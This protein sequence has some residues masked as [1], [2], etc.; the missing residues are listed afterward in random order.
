MNPFFLSAAYI[1]DFQ[2]ARLASARRSQFGTPSFTVVIIERVAGG[3]R[4]LAAAVERWAAGVGE[5][6][7]PR[8]LSTQ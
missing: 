2:R 7:C 1:E 8:S 4:R 3:L 6:D 5:A